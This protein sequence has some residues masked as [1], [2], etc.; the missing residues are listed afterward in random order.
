MY[1]SLINFFKKPKICKNCRCC[2][3]K[4]KSNTKEQEYSD[5]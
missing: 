1:L 2:K 3:I 5:F 4:V